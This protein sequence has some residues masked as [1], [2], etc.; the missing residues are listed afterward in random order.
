LGI[1]GNAY[2]KCLQNGQWGEPDVF[3]CHTPEIM[4]LEM[5]AKSLLSAG[6]NETV[7]PETVINI[8]KELINSLNTSKSIFPSDVSSIANILDAVIM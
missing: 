4:T 6:D 2:R 1:S 3:E 5:E 8:T 7:T